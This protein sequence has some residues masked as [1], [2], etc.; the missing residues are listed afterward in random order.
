[1]TRAE[2]FSSENIERSFRTSS[3]VCMDGKVLKRPWTGCSLWRN[4]LLV[5]QL[6]TDIQQN[7]LMNLEESLQ[8]LANGSPAIMLWRNI[9][10]SKSYLCRTV[11][12]TTNP[13]HRHAWRSVVRVFPLENLAFLSG[14]QT[15]FS[16]HARGS[17]T[18]TIPANILNVGKLP[19]TRYLQDAC[20]L[21]TC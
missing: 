18:W 1:M 10:K 19:P 3:P 2:K 14:S 5:F 13:K 6:A 20:V 17:C 12:I 15:I 4:A 16:L 7:Q 9:I 21:A 8:S 11:N